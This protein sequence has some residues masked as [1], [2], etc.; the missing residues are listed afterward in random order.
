MSE[1]ITDQRRRQFV[2][3]GIAGLAGVALSREVLTRTAMAQEQLDENDPQA[4]A[5]KYSHDGSSATAENQTC[6]NCQLYTG[7]ADAEW[8]PCSIFPN[9][10]VNAKGWCSAWVV[11]SG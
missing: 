1:K 8:G 9:K 10:L 4:Q 3:A 11:K 7:A 5:L 2:K 6:A